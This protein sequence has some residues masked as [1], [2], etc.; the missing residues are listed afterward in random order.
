MLE[1]R[2]LNEYLK[3]NNLP[4]KLE[5]SFDDMNR[6]FKALSDDSDDEDDSLTLRESLELCELANAGSYK[7]TRD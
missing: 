1:K 4:L 6:A 3:A 5:V 7:H 2:S